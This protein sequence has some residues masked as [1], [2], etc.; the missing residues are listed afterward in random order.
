MASTKIYRPGYVNDF[1]GNLINDINS[2][3]DSD[4]A[5][6]DYASLND[7]QKSA[8]NKMMSGENFNS[9]IDQLMGA[10]EAG[11]SALDN[12]YSKINDLYSSGKATP[13]SIESLTDQLY[14]RGAVQQGIEAANQKSERQFSTET[15][16]AIAQQTLSGGWSGGSGGW[17]SSN[18]LAQ[19]RAQEALVNEEQANA[20]QIA[21]NAYNNAQQQA[22]SIFNANAANTK[23]ALA[24]LSANA[25]ALAS[26]YDAAALMTQNKLTQSVDASQQ[27]LQDQQNRLNV[28]YQNQIGAQ[29]QYL[30]NIQNRLGAASAA[31]GVLGMNSKT[32]VSGGGGGI[33][34]G[35]ISGA[36]TGTM[37]GGFPYG[38]MAGAAI[39]GA[40]AA[41][42]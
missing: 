22:T 42:Q 35:M 21:N 28:N 5:N 11:T 17:G 13:E 29:N 19:S 6:L 14:N 27:Q 34:G 33:L 2:A 16:P 37:T 32:T 31:N 40:A 9:Y 36:V 12:A 39:G 30:N 25:G 3:K 8:L 18:R 38:T 20:D 7:D 26:N 1:T 23:S 4:Y 24:G 15:N 41:S 10:G